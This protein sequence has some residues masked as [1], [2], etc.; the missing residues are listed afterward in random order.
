[1]LAEL[2]PL[3]GKRATTHWGSVQFMRETYRDVSMEKDVR[4]VDE[5]RIVTSAGISAGID[6][7]LHIVARLHGEDVADWTAWRMEYRWQP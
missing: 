1:M 2:G 3:N 6:M 5:G 4:F 7:S